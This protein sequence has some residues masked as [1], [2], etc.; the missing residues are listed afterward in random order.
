MSND[1]V[2]VD[3]FDDSHLQKYVQ[4]DE[5]EERISQL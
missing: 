5:N 4:E 1:I 2:S 3:R